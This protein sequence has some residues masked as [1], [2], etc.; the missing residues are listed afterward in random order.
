MSFTANY[1]TCVQ[2]KYCIGDV[3]CLP[4]HSIML[5]LQL[6]NPRMFNY[7]PLGIFIY[8]EDGNH[9]H[10][11]A[12]VHL[13][14]ILDKLSTSSN[15]VLNKKFL[16]HVSFILTFPSSTLTDRLQEP[17]FLLYEPNEN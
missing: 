7:A 5:T 17:Y 14:G 15:A 10:S 16:K 12:F 2:S 6:L 11:G 13:G 8:L 4:E 9:V 3:R 1:V